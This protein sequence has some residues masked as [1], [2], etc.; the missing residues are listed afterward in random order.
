MD[1]SSGGAFS[2]TAEMPVNSTELET[3][4]TI[5]T[6][7]HGLAS[8]TSCGRRRAA[9]PSRL[10]VALI[11]EDESIEA[12]LCEA[13]NPLSVSPRRFLT[14]WQ[15]EQRSLVAICDLLI[16]DPCQGL[17]PDDPFLAKWLRPDQGVRVILLTQSPTTRSVVAVMKAGAESVLDK[18]VSSACLRSA[19]SRV[20]R[21][22]D[23]SEHPPGGEQPRCGADVLQVLTAQQRRVAE[24]I[25]LGKSNR[26]IAEALLIAV[27]TV[28]SHR[29]QIMKRL[30]L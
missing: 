16:L 29:G 27:K 8:G 28:E 24:L 3:P 20:I 19:I 22:G 13:L 21:A 1:E 17:Q 4:M 12:A 6:R 5:Q 14:P 2:R 11:T 18:P 9:L 23:A 26:Q 25:Y 30:Q 10:R 15:F 7:H